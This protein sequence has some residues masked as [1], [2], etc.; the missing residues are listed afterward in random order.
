[1]HPFEK[2]YQDSIDSG[3]LAGVTLAAQNRD[4][5]FKYNKSFGTRSL[6]AGSEDLPMQSDTILWIAS[7]TKLMTAIAALQYVERGLIGLDD[8]VE[9]ILPEVGKFGVLTGLDDVG[10]P[11][12]VPKEG[13]ITLRKLMCHTSGYTYDLMDPNLTKWRKTQGQEPWQGETIEEKC[14]MPTIFQPG[15]SWIYGAGVDWVGKLIERVSGETL[16]VYMAKHI[17]NPL[18]I[19]DIT[20][21]P[22]RNP[23]LKDRMAHIS[24]LDPSGGKSFPVP[25]D[26][27]MNAGCKECMGGGGVYTSADTY[28]QLLV[29][30]LNADPKLLAPESW[31]ELFKPQLEQQQVEA[32]QAV[33]SSPELGSFYRMYIPTTAKKNWSFGGLLLEEGCEGMSGGTMLW[34]GVPCLTWFVDREAGVCGFAGTQMVPPMA[35][36]IVGLHGNFHRE[37]LGI[38]KE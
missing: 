18:N 14:T 16:E 38:A 17:W 32:M 36:T 26:F 28:M 27:D 15:S 22:E 5:S 4:G 23:D 20:F 31:K 8:D 3:V 13:K 11:V 1:M 24:S 10:E 6:R 7:C 30:V 33:M 9:T 37:I 25:D 2:I 12:L 35:P 19:K 21:F 34:G 29:A